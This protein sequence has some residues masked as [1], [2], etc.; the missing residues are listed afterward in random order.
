MDRGVGVVVAGTLY[1]VSIGTHRLVVVEVEPIRVCV[2]L[3]NRAGAPTCLVDLVPV[4]VDASPAADL[5]ASWMADDVDVR[6]VDGLQQ[7]LRHG[8]AILVE[9]RVHRGDANVEAV[10]KLRWPI[11]RPIRTDVE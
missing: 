5:P 10:K 1:A 4:C 8:V 11:D 7:A 3:E 9:V 2:D 6:I